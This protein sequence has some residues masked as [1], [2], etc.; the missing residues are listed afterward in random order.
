MAPLWRPL[1]TIV[2]M[3]HWGLSS[4]ENPACQ[5]GDGDSDSDADADA[6]VNG[7]LC[8]VGA[9]VDDN[10]VAWDQVRR[11]LLHPYLETNWW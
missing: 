11:P 6:D 9:I 3:M 5:D 1:P 8:S 7:D 10:I 2:G 4:V